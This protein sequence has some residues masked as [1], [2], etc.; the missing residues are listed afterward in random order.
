MVNST[1]NTRRQDVI[2][3]VSFYQCGLL[4]SKSNNKS[5]VV[6]RQGDDR[7]YRGL[8]FLIQ[9]L[10]E[11]VTWRVMPAIRLA[12]TRFASFQPPSILDGLT[13]LQ[14]GTLD[15]W[16]PFETEIQPNELTFS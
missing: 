15:V 7:R 11:G 1:P 14:Y 3:Q 2:D 6:G 4:F 10:R 5:S 8:R 13:H 9:R 12:N 16:L